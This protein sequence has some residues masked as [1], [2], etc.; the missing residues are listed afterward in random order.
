MNGD[1]VAVL[2]LDKHVERR[3][4]LALEDR[5]LRPS[6]ARLLV[7]QGHALDAAE[8]VVEGGVDQKVLERL[9][10]RRGDELHSALGDRARGY[11]LELGADLV[12]DDDLG[13]VVLDC[14]D[15][16]R[17]LQHRRPHLHA[18][19]AAD[20]RM[21]NVAVAADLVRGVDDDDPLALLVGE[22]P[23]ALA[24]DRRLADPGPPEEEDRLPGQRD[25]PDDLGGAADRPADSAGEADDPAAPVADG[26]DAV[27]RPLDAGPV[28]IAELADP[29]GDVVEVGRGHRPVG[30]EHLPPGHP[31]L[32]LAPEVE[33]DL[34]QL[35]GIDPVVEGLVEVGG[36]RLGEELDLGIPG[37]LAAAD[38]GIGHQPNAGTIPFSR[39]GTRWASSL[40]ISD[41]LTSVSKPRLRRASIMC[42]S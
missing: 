38:D 30:E 1:A 35:G 25:V 29:V 13:H 26:G 5:L 34:Q 2:D 42:E 15:H 41:W 7:R 20:S 32:R 31:G 6:P 23:G 16:H 22:H 12:D 21:R 27:Q 8:Q 36:Q 24:Q 9:A 11:G 3:R 14:L 33:H 10:V 17:V 4:S 37:R 40:T 18:A 39:A 28:V 19:C